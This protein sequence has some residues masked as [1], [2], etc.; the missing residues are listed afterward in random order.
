MSRLSKSTTPSWSGTSKANSRLN[1]SSPRLIVKAVK[2]GH[3]GADR[4]LQRQNGRRRPRSA[5][6][7]RPCAA[8]ASR[9]R[10]FSQQWRSNVEV[11]PDA[12]GPLVAKVFRTRIDP[13][14]QKL[15]FIRVF[16]GTIRR[17]DSVHASSA[18]KEHQTGATPGS[19]WR[20]NQPGR[21]QRALV[22]LSPSPK[23]KICTQARLSGTTSCRKPISQARWSASPSRPNREETKPSCPEHLHK[24]LE[25]DPTFPPRS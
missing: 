9:F 7:D 18:K 11:K 17:D 10:S 16:S 15:N 2:E 14:V 4:L 5:G 6:Y 8:F 13:F 23:W 20:T 22:T 19:H 24:V 12:N 25:E 21:R 3:L 1:K